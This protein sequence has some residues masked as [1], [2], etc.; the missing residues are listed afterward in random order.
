M[1]GGKVRLVRQ[2]QTAGV[3][4]LRED[5]DSAAVVLKVV[6]NKKL[7]M[8]L[9]LTEAMRMQDVR[10]LIELAHA[11]K[12][13][14]PYKMA[15][16]QTKADQCEDVVYD[17]EGGHIRSI[18]KEET[19]LQPGKYPM[20]TQLN[21]AHHSGLT[22]F[23]I[24]EKG[25]PEGAARAELSISGDGNTIAST[26]RRAGAQAGAEES[27]QTT[28]CSNG[29]GREGGQ[30]QEGSAAARDVN[31]PCS[32]TSHSPGRMRKKSR[33]NAN[34]E[35]EKGVGDLCGSL[36]L[37]GTPGERPSERQRDNENEMPSRA[38]LDKDPMS[39]PD[40]VENSI[41]DEIE[42]LT[43]G[44]EINIFKCSS[45]QPENYTPIDV[46]SD[47]EASETDDEAEGGGEEPEKGKETRGDSMDERDDDGSSENEEKVGGGRRGKNASGSHRRSKH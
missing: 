26:Q 8:H 22:L 13:S 35:L 4:V 31:V 1:G 15:Y 10:D 6:S 24:M 29:G 11:K 7:E 41:L 38:F 47:D 14:A 28:S 2:N 46:G 23:A 44:P 18:S 34:K 45:D 36:D 27:R 33:K 5:S 3:I 16:L 39:L 42:E 17:I 43:Y 9:H 25:Q 12:L 20:I 21:A 30:G 32:S 19:G 37:S 40:A